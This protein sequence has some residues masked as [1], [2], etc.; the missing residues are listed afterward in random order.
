MINNF[1]FGSGPAVSYSLMNSNWDLCYVRVTW[2]TF[3]WCIDCHLQE[4]DLG[5]SKHSSCKVNHL[6]IK[7]ALKSFPKVFDLCFNFSLLPNELIFF[8]DD[9]LP[10]STKEEL[11]RL[12]HLQE[13]TE[14]NSQ[15]IELTKFHNS[16]W[17]IYM[18][19]AFIDIF[20]ISMS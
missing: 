19:L 17:D 20:F 2:Q 3:W 10:V 5:L 7:S 1:F 9:T 15:H 4:Y 13:I 11:R 18:Y 14:D 8:L 6:K 16:F 12:G